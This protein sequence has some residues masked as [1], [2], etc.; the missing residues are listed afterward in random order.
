[1]KSKLFI[2]IALLLFG[3]ALKAQ[4]VLMGVQTNEAVRQEAQQA[5]AQLRDCNC[6]S[7][8]IVQPALDLP[9][10]DDFSTTTIY[11]DKQL[12]VDNAVFINKDFAYRPPNLGTATFDAVDSAGT[13]YKE[14]E[15]FPPI[16]GDRLTSRPIRLD[17][18]LSIDRALTPADS[19]Y[20]S[21][22]YQPQGVGYSFPQS[23]DTLML[24]FGIPSGDSAFVGMDSITVLADVLMAPNQEE[25]VMFDTLWSPSNLGCNPLVFMINYNPIPIVRGD[26]ITI[27]CDSVFEPV[28]SWTKV[29]WSEG[30]SLSDFQST[31]NKNFVQVMV[32]LLDSTWFHPEFQFRFV[33]YI[34][35]VNDLSPDEKVNG[36]YWNVDYVYL[37]YNRSKRDTTYRVLTFSERAPSFLRDYQVMP[38][39]QYR[40]D[41]TNSVRPQFNMYIANLDNVAHNTTY[42]YRVNQVSGNYGYRYDGGSCNLSPVYTF[43]FQDCA[44]CAA[45]ACPPVQA[46]FNL[47]YNTDTTSYVIKHFISDSS[48]INPIVDSA[49]YRQ[50]FY[51]YYAYDDG[52]PEYGFGLEAPHNA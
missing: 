3:T 41:P 25:I 52:T 11:P 9:F 20:L 5:D 17:S 24:Q 12:W 28:T 4:I 34:T 32:P 18:L 42:E 6:K 35:V 37:N 26:Y 33:N 39:R 8:A 49:I 23:Y 46:Y 38:Y 29:W 50:G 10:F 40:A 30:L 19:L 21:F 47:D 48:D 2:F 45:H 13:V 14:A 27:L 31:Y 7:S 15:W 1:M 36:D 44:D 51:N 16:V 22:Y 43:G